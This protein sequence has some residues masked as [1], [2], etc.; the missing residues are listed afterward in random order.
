[1]VLVLVIETVWASEYEYEYEYHFIEYEYDFGR[2]S[3]TSKL[4]SRADN[5]IHSLARRAGIVQ[6]HQECGLV[7]LV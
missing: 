1:M 7:Q 6:D 4:V 2:N 3:A 5:R